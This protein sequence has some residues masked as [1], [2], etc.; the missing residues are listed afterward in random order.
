MP[1]KC[2]FTK[3]EI[4]AAALRI[5]RRA[6][7]DAVTA[8]SVAAELGSSPKIIFS[9]Y[10]NMQELRTDMIS[11]AKTLY[12]Q[13]IDNDMAAGEYPPYKASGMAY[14]R[15]ASEEPELFRL[16][17]MRD[18]SAEKYDDSLDEIEPF[19]AIIQQTLGISRERA[20]QL[21]LQLW[22]HVHGFATMIA[23]NYLNFDQDTISSFLSD[24]YFSLRDR[25]IAGEEKQT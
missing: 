11:S 4:L 13:Y 19:I 7:F 15:F 8:R 14:I 25:Y 21:H 20:V 2:K 17:Y 5:T 24:I 6:G 16:L 10:Q 1:P 22:I 18:R 9:S 23:T 3:E 12:Q